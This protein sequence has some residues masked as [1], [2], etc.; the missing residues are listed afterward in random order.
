MSKTCIVCNSWPE[1]Q[2]FSE[3]DLFELVSVTSEDTAMLDWLS[4]NVI[5]NDIDPSIC[6]AHFLKENFTRDCDERGL[7]LLQLANNSVTPTFVT[8]EECLSNNRISSYTD[9]LLHY[10]KCLNTQPNWNMEATE[11][12]VTFML[13]RYEVIIR[14]KSNMKVIVQ[15]GNS[16][17]EGG[18]ILESNLNNGFAEFWSKMRSLMLFCEE[19]HPLTDVMTRLGATIMLETNDEEMFSSLDDVLCYIKTILD[20][21]WLYESVP[22]NNFIVGYQLQSIG[23]PRISK[24]IRVNP[25]FSMIGHVSGEIIGTKNPGTIRFLQSMNQQPIEVVETEDE[26]ANWNVSGVDPSNPDQ[27]Q[28]FEMLVERIGEHILPEWQ[29][30]VVDTNLLLY[31]T[32]M[33]TIPKLKTVIRINK[34]LNCSM[35]VNE[36]GIV[37]SSIIPGFEESILTFTTLEL[38]MGEQIELSTSTDDIVAPEIEEGEI[39]QEKRRNDFQEDEPA[40]KRQC[41]DGDSD[42][43]IITDDPLAIVEPPKLR[44][45][46]LPEP[47][48]SLKCPECGEVKANSSALARHVIKHQTEFECQLCGIVFSTPQELRSHMDST[49][50]TTVYFKCRHCQRTFALEKDLKTHINAEHSVNELCPICDAPFKSMENMY[51]H[52]KDTHRIRDPEG[53][54][55]C[56]ICRSAYKHSYTMNRHF[57]DCH[58]NYPHFKHL[59]CRF[60]ESPLVTCRLCGLQNEQ[61]SFMMRHMKLH[62]PQKRKKRTV[63]TFEQIPVEEEGEICSEIIENNEIYDEIITGDDFHEDFNS[64]NDQQNYLEE[65]EIQNYD[66]EVEFQCPNSGCSFTS[67]S[68]EAL[69]I[70]SKCHKNLNLSLHDEAEVINLSD[71]EDSSKK[72][73]EKPYHCTVCPYKGATYANLAQHQ[74]YHKS[75]FQCD[76]C[77]RYFPSKFLLTRHRKIHAGRD[78]DL[79]ATNYGQNIEEGEVLPVKEVVSASYVQI[80]DESLGNCDEIDIKEESI[81]G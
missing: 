36:T 58:I 5:Y 63:V 54:S 7:P 59:K 18:S 19:N 79:R 34:N 51:E 3:N 30:V 20:E 4:M 37:M 78:Y 49:H 73:K 11:S 17:F 24:S 80:V 14:V 66:Q 13:K 65:G 21:N 41:P 23:I 28:S 1:F 39:L 53:R 27:I 12:E 10:H 16:I 55:I 64:I 76:I 69:V 62:F 42:V 61:Y 33:R 56:P 47:S 9:F 25:D 68:K 35:F 77:E 26:E 48:S 60:D 2:R 38:L 71:D 50:S 45:K 31:K 15:E 67:N 6:E 29:V 72:E 81:L 46:S 52:I 57:R 44:K 75:N 43:E 40:S 22:E 8:Y 70:H 74:G 32:D